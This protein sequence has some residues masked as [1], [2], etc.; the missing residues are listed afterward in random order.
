[1]LPQSPLN[2]VFVKMQAYDD[3]VHT[4]SGITLYKDTTYNPE[5]SA[6]VS[7]PVLST[8]RSVREADIDTEGIKEFVK[9]GDTLLFRY[10]VI[11]QKDQRDNDTDIHHNQFFINGEAFWKVDYSMILGVIRKGKIIPAPGY[12]YCTPIIEK[13][14]EKEGSLFIP[15]SMQQ[16]ILQNKAVVEAVGEPKK[17]C[18]ELGLTKGDTIIFNGIMAEKYEIEGSNYLVIRQEYIKAK[19]I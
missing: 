1:M 7:A 12:V 14:E 8:P 16:K 17:G 5:W 19:E 9:K 2:K 10:M 6:T 13:T 3:L 18:I 11:I 4:K 15:E